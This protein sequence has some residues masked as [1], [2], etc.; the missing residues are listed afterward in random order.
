MQFAN[1]VQVLACM[2][3][4][5]QTAFAAPMEQPVSTA[6]TTTAPTATAVQDMSTA[7][8]ASQLHVLS[9]KVGKSGGE[10]KQREDTNTLA[11]EPRE[12]PD[13]VNHGK[14]LIDYLDYST[15][16]DNKLPICYKECMLSEN[17]KG[18]LPVKV[19]DTT[20]G[21]FCNNEIVTSWWIVNHVHPC[22]DWGCRV[23]LVGTARAATNWMATVCPGHFGNK[24]KSRDTIVEPGEGTQ[25]ES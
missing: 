2:A 1:T 25:L 7:V 13:S 24:L 21:D 14:K 5:A 17:G 23:D 12:T 22:I 19:W 20:L 8:I 6:I 11:L 18:V 10:S 15:D 9:P 3:L 16:P 4:A